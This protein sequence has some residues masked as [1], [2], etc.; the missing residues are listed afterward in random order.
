MQLNIVVYI[1]FFLFLLGLFDLIYFKG[2]VRV[3]WGLQL[4]IFSILINFLSFSFFLYQGSLWDKTMMIM[5]L[6][7]VYML[8]FMLFFYAYSILEGERADLMIQLNFFEWDKSI[9]WGEDN[10]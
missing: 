3:A 9:W 6:I 2:L 5:A 1:S 10:R 4:I 7:P 8:L